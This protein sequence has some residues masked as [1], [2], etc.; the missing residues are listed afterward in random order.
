MTIRERFK[1]KHPRIYARI[2]ECQKEQDNKPN[3][4]LFLHNMKHNGNF[5]WEDTEEGHDFWNNID[6]DDTEKYQIFYDKYPEEKFVLPEK[7]CVKITKENLKKLEIWGNITFSY[8]SGYLTSTKLWYETRL[9]YTEITFAQFQQYVL[10]EPKLAT[11]EEVTKSVEKTEFK[12]GD[13]IVIVS[14]RKNLDN[15]V[16]NFIYKQQKNYKC[17]DVEKSNNNYPY[18]TGDVKF[19]QSG[20]KWRYATEQ[21]IAEYQRINKPYDVTTLTKVETIEKWSVGSYVVIT[22]KTSGILLP[23]GTVRKIKAFNGSCVTVDGDYLAIDRERDNT[24]KWFATKQEAEEF[25][26]TLTKKVVEEKSETLI[27]GKYKIGDIVVSLSSNGYR[28]TGELFEVLPNPNNKYD[29]ENL[30]YI[31]DTCSS[32]ISDWRIATQEEKEAFEKGIK[33][34]NDIKVDKVSK[35][36]YEVGKW[37]KTEEMFGKFLELTKNNCFYSS[38]HYIGGY[39]KS[40]WEFNPGYTWIPATIEELRNFLPEGH[41]DR[42]E[43]KT[44]TMEEFK[45]GDWIVTNMFNTDN[46]KELKVVQILEDLS[47]SYSFDFIYKTSNRNNPF[48]TKNHEHI[49]NMYGDTLR[50]ALP[51]E[52]P[53]NKESKNNTMSNEELLA[54]ARKHYVIGVK[55]QSEDDGYRT[56]EIQPFNDETTV[57]WCISGND[58]RCD[59]GMSTIG[60]FCSNPLIYNGNTK[61]WATI[62]STPKVEE[63]VDDELRVGDRVECVVPYLSNI[64][65][66]MTGVLIK[67]HTTEKHFVGIKWDNFT[68]GHTLDGALSKDDSNKGYFVKKENVKKIPNNQ[69]LNIARQYLYGTDA[70]ETAIETIYKTPTENNQTTNNKV[71]L[72]PTKEVYVRKSKNN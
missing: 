6:N 21:E 64:S 3:D 44:E 51:H 70:I 56:R 11:Q 42:Q 55:F 17:L 58:V 46:Q 61:K 26:K 8:V 49:Y 36:E 59:N 12:K 47:S 20:D 33:N 38:E 68:K 22:N 41:I 67:N 13:Y 69:K 65:K 29:T 57:K 72:L 25:A 63:I 54:Y 50:K 19:N 4:E 27:F 5:H 52:I 2:L 48:N 53:T 43:T 37:Y 30:Y 28:A 15:V 23:T 32:A 24:I 45:V 10:K 14:G 18:T 16:D 31:S 1:E 62:V 34:I 66:G 40:T 9:N 35:V 60:G 39:Y 7:W 71:L